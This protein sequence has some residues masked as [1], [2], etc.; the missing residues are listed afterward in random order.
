MD[1][2]AYTK[3]VLISCAQS[4]SVIVGSDLA[5]QSGLNGDDINAVLDAIATECKSNNQPNLTA[6]VVQAST[7]MPSIRH[8]KLYN[9]E[10]VQ[11]PRRCRK[12]LWLDIRD[13]IYAHYEQ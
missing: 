11:A 13:E 2:V 8:F 5:K 4:K 1:K 12:L 7:G 3:D 10:V 9:E 6:L